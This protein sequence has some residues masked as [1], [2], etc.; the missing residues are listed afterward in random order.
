M[1]TETANPTPLPLPLADRI[2][3][4]IPSTRPSASRSGPPEL[5]RLIAAS[6]WIA[7]L[8]GK[9]V[10]ASIERLSAETTPTDSDCSSPNGEPIAAT[11][12]PTAIFDES[13]SGS[14]R[15][16]RSPGS[17]LISPTSALG[18]YPTIL[19]SSWLPSANCT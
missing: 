8:I 3:E 17:T 6:V 14:G 15:S 5:P 11:G 10:S 19:A 1:L 7:P 12:S 4:L 9:P 13:P 18:S 2:C 16:A